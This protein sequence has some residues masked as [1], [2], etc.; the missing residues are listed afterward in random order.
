ML[1]PPDRKLTLLD[2]SAAVNAVQNHPLT[3]N[4]ANGM[5]YTPD[6][7]PTH[8]DPSR[9]GPAATSV[10]NQAAATGN[11]LSGLANSRQQPTY[12]A[13]NGETLTREMCSA[14]LSDDEADTIP[15]YH[16]FFYTLLSVS[17]A[18]T[19]THEQLLNMI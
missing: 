6:R 18:Q 15:D 14:A 11:E 17:T 3:Q 8:A 9:I 5:L 12:T 13:A 16:S 7:S 10:K 2:A 4:L 19:K 1:P